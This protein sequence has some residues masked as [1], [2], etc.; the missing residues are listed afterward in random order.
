MYGFCKKRH[1]GNSHFVSDKSHTFSCRLKLYGFCQKPSRSTQNDIK[2]AQLRAAVDRPV[3]LY[4]IDE[5]N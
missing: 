4:S 5:Q 1:V 3:C 2:H